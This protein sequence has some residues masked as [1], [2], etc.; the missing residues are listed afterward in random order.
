MGELYSHGKDC[1]SPTHPTLSQPGVVPQ[2]PRPQGGSR[3]V[4]D[5]TGLSESG[6]SCPLLSHFGAESSGPFYAPTSLITALED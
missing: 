3:V 4:G 1:P 2:F 6:C 5:H